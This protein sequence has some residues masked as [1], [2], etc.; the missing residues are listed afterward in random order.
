MRNGRDILMEIRYRFLMGNGSIDS[1]Y[2]Q[3]GYALPPLERA[4]NRD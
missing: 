4:E 3:S 1:S 2:W